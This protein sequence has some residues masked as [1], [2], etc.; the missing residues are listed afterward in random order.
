VVEGVI[1]MVLVVM[2]GMVDRTAMMVLVVT[3]V[4]VLLKMVEVRKGAI[5]MVIVDLLV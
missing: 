2:V 4:K 3:M 1:L 5:L